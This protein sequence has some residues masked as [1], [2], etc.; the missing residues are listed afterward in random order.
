MGLCQLGRRVRLETSWVE[1]S[2]W[3]RSPPS[4][5]LN[6]IKS[7]QDTP[8]PRPP[9]SLI[10]KRLNPCL[11]GLCRGCEVF[12]VPWLYDTLWPC[13]NRS[14]KRSSCIP[15]WTMNCHA[16]TILSHTSE[17]AAPW[18]KVSR[19]IPLCPCSYVVSSRPFHDG[20]RDSTAQGRCFRVE[21]K[22]NECPAVHAFRI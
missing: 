20:A 11:L 18:N 19:A 8:S 2:D 17:L 3:T 1:S 22:G 9:E 7:R 10:G 5:S 14:K 6:E 12:T 13:T 4:G 16:E 15:V 21:N